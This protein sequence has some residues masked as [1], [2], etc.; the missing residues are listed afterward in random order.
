MKYVYEV[1]CIVVGSRMNPFGTL[2]WQGFDFVI[3]TTGDLF[4]PD[5]GALDSVS[6]MLNNQSRLM[7]VQP[8]LYPLYAAQS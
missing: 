7:E 2:P 5:M 1:D 4:T 3:V 6:R 8:S